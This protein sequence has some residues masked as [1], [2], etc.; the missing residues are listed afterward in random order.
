LRG[1]AHS[2]YEFLCRDGHP[3]RGRFNVFQQLGERRAQD[4]TEERGVGL[5]KGGLRRKLSVRP[6]ESPVFVP[7]RIV[8]QP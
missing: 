7:A 5:G 3:V 8:T 6:N 2:S 1:S 4:L